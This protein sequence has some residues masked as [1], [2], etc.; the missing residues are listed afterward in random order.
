MISEAKVKKDIQVMLACVPEHDRYLEFAVKH[1]RA[2]LK[3]SGKALRTQCIYI[4]NTSL[5][6]I[7]PKATDIRAVLQEFTLQCTCDGIHAFD[8]VEC[9]HKG[10]GSH[11]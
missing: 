7:H 1:C 6:W 3:L 5:G 10:K 11:R 8:R 2:A 4:L 9:P